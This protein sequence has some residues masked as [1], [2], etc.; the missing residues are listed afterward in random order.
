MLGFLLLYR[1]FRDGERDIWER[2]VTMSSSSSS[3]SSLSLSL[4]KI[5]KHFEEREK[6]RKREWRIGSE[7]QESATGEEQTYVTESL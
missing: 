5:C 4:Q 7:K 1:K 6:E 2:T 3:C